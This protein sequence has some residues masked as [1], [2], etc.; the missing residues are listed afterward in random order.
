[1]GSRHLHW[2]VE[3]GC[4]RSTKAHGMRQLSVSFERRLVAPARVDPE[5]SRVLRGTT[6]GIFQAARFD[7]SRPGH[8]ANRGGHPRSFSIEGM[9]SSEDKRSIGVLLLAPTHPSYRGVT[10]PMIGTVL[11]EF[12]GLPSMTR[13]LYD[14]YTRT[15]RSRS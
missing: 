2:M 12:F 6:G 13:S 11:I 4:T 15:L 8:I 7:A 5:Q 9:K 1:M 10:Y 14:T 3:R